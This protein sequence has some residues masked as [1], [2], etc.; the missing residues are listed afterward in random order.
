M[1][2]CHYEVSRDNR[3]EQRVEC[4]LRPGVVLVQVQAGGPI[5]ADYRSGLSSR[6]WKAV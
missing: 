5:L 1:I 2:T 6:F 3:K 4:I